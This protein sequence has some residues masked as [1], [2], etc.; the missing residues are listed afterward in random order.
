LLWT[1]EK[2]LGKSWTPDIADAWIS[3]A[4]GAAEIAK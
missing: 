1:F 4:Y 2:E 3:E